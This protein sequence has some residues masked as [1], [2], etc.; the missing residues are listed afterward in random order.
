MGDPNYEG[1]NQAA[2]NSLQ[3]ALRRAWPK[4]STK[5]NR[6]DR[7]TPFPF[8]VL[9]DGSGECEGGV[10]T[11]LGRWVCEGAPLGINVQIPI[12]TVEKEAEENLRV[13][14]LTAHKGNHVSFVEAKEA[15]EVVLQRYLDK[16]FAGEPIRREVQPLFKRG[17]VSRGS[18]SSSGMAPG[19]CGL[20][21]TYIG[22]E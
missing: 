6:C 10:E 14:V 13:E 11:D 4:H 5:P 18:A 8:Q 7:G 20:S 2:V 21:S 3:E 1:P 15:A 16:E 12:N 9:L 19:S 22:P 17:P